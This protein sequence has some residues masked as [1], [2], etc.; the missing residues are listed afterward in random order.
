[1]K[2]VDTYLTACCTAA[3]SSF[4]SMTARWNLFLSPV[5]IASSPIHS[6]SKPHKTDQNGGVVSAGEYKQV[7]VLVRL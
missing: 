1:M 3:S 6:V 7:G 2:T 4:S 5:I